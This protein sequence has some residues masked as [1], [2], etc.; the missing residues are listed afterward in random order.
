ME[1]RVILAIGLCVAV[2]IAWTKFF[3]V[4]PPTPAPVAQTAPAAKAEHGAVCNE[5]AS[6]ARRLRDTP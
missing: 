6:L 1:K 4:R 5:L 3:P 2:M